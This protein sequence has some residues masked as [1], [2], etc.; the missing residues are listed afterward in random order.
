MRSLF[1]FL[2]L[3]LGYSSFS[4]RLEVKLSHLSQVCTESI[5][6][7]VTG[8]YSSIHYTSDGSIPSKISKELKSPLKI[9]SN[10]AL[11][12]KAY[13]KALKKD[14]LIARSFIF[15]TISKLPIVS[16]TIPNEDLWDSNNGIYTKGNGAYFSDS[17]GHWENCNF[18]QKW[19]KEI[20]IVYI[21][22]TRTEV[23][24]QPCG[25]RIFGESTRR[26]PDKSL[27]IVARKQYG[28]SRFNYPFFNEKSNIQEYK[29]LV[30]RTSGNDYNST[31]FKDVLNAY[32]ARNLGLDYMAYQQVRMYV[33]G[34]YWG[35]YNLRE[36]INKH[37]L[38][39]NHG[40]SVDSSSI[41][42]GRWVNQHG[43]RSRYKEMYDW[44]FNLDK[45][46]SLSYLKAKE[47]LEVRNYIN[48]RAFQ[49]F[50]NNVDS[51]GNIRYWNSKDLDGKFRMIL[52]DTDL[53]YSATD[54]NYLAKCLSPI[55][56][57]WYNNTWS[58]IYFRKLM[59]N[60]DFKN[61]FINQYAHLMNT[62]LHT[63]TIIAAVNKFEAIYKDELPRS[64]SEVAKH[65][66]SAPIPLDKW[67]K[68][69]DG[70][71]FF[72]KKRPEIARSE[73]TNTLSNDGTFYLK[74]EGVNGSV[75]I[76]K[77]YPIKLPFDGLYYKNI[78]LPISIQPDS[79]YVFKGWEN[80]TMNLD[81]LIFTSKDT[82]RLNP[83]FEIIPK[84]IKKELSVQNKTI[85][86]KID[87]KVSI[88][89]LL[90]WV[91]IGLGGVLLIVYFKLRIKTKG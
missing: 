51:R 81:S 86:K 22:C 46:D 15:D 14:T 38:Y 76:N 50:L 27:K 69:V 26:Q 19:E 23:I 70:Y 35:L 10:K 31:R 32:L 57:D 9:K 4:Q 6:L 82:I 68:K 8:N 25:L 80:G 7:S 60:Q 49:I 65:L 91:F 12:I 84:P 24:N 36:K 77:N 17:T 62:A 43:D 74:V 5:E 47:Y 61:D 58:T 64:S 30:I 48:Y 2:I 44:F 83:R 72:A 73:I 42:M 63:D 66:R 41:I 79:G 11:L 53:S 16:I 75:I 34:E 29:Q 87:K 71:R 3:L 59:E 54:R 88:L 55:K 37:Y 45:M 90:A 67:L 1:L 56:T 20:Q 85:E 40:A 28:K 13:N 39:Y 33:N 18:Q 52:Y 21:D 89:W 78:P